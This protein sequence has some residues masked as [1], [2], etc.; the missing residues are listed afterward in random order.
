MR[1]MALKASRKDAA[2][3]ILIACRGRARN[4]AASTAM[5]ITPNIACCTSAS[6]HIGSWPSSRP[7]SAK[8]PLGPALRTISRAAQ[9]TSPSWSSTSRLRTRCLFEPEN[10]T[11]AAH[12][13]LILIILLRRAARSADRKSA[14]SPAE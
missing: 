12:C 11:P 13:L 2:A 9:T 3:M 10:S 8:G 7:S 4:S 14:T 6:V 1:M 5:F